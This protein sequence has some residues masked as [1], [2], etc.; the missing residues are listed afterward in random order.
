[1][2]VILLSARDLGRFHTQI[3]DLILSA[4]LLPEFLKFPAA[5]PALNSVL[6]HLQLLSCGFSI[7]PFPPPVAVVVEGTV[8]VSVIRA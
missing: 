2:G 5:L 4:L 1:M 8:F 6:W 7:P 3:L